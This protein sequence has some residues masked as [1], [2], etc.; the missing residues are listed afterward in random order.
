V[1]H[2]VG[3][4]TLDTSSLSTTFNEQHDDVQVCV[5]PTFGGG[6]DHTRSSDRR[7]SGG[8][9]SAG[10]SMMVEPTASHIQIRMPSV[11]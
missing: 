6:Q 1:S 7:L 10:R 9:G 3:L 4:G 8:T 2:A 5:G 11:D